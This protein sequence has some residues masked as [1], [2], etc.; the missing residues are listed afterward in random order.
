[1]TAST[2]NG[3]GKRARSG[4]QTLTLLSSHRNRLVLQALAGGP[5]RQIDLRRAAGSPA[6]TTLRGHLKELEDNGAIAKRRR[7]AFPGAL[8]YEL[9]KPGRG[10]LFVA[11]VLESWLS[12]APKEPLQPGG[13]TAKAAIKALVGGWSTTMLRALAARPVSLTELDSVIAD[14]N[15]PSLERRLTAM[16]HAGLVEA[17]PANG[18]GTPYTITDWARRAMAPLSSAIHWERRNAP[19]R[20][21][22]VGK[23]DAEATFLLAIPLLRLAKDLSGGCRMAVEMPNGS[24][25]RFAGVTVEVRAGKIQALA[26]RLGGKPNAWASGSPLAWLRTVVEADSDGLELG[27]DGALARALLEGLHRSLFGRGLRVP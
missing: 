17:L 10:L 25:P 8:E 19:D 21:P 20:T 3:S 23:L 1:L 11:T 26:A 12:H 6:Q 14:L 4:A 16:R 2:V 13:D 5:K 18:R 15:Y 9:E 27:G 24:G 7:N 22:T